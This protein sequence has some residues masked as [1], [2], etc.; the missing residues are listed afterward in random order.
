MDETYARTYPPAPW[1]LR[2]TMYAALWRLPG[3]LLPGHWEL[4]EPARPL[5]VGRHALVVTAWVDY[6]PGGTLAYR[7]LLV[8]L[9]V[10]ERWRVAACAVEAWVDDERSLA[11]GRAL[12]GVPKRP[13]SF[14]F[15][16]P[17]PRGTVRTGLFPD[18][19]AATG[20]AGAPVT[21]WH[22]DLLRLPGPLPAR[23]R[24]LQPAP[25]PPGGRRTL[26]VPLRLTGRVR[27]G[28]ARLAARP[29]G[30]LAFLAGRTPLLAL[31][32]R[33]FRF[34]VGRAGS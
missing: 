32:V 9:A 30:P 16:A 25:G 18:G 7:E 17:S 28:R 12:W 33:D 31:S 34:T 21:A 29:G 24:L 20:D 10:R 5:L 11:G 27:L 8:A 1:H 19:R 13:G 2:G 3:R 22:Q 15:A 6:R 26:R 14:A 4:P 23:G